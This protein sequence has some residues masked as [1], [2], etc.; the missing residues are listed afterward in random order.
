[1]S[2]QKPANI[3]FAKQNLRKMSILKKRGE[4]LIIFLLSL[5]WQAGFSG[6]KI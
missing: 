1:M 5:Y 3:C 4:V 6:V 2:A